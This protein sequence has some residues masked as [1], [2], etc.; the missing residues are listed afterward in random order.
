MEEKLV[1]AISVNPELY[2]MCD[3]NNHNREESQWWEQIG[4][5][6]NMIGELFFCCF[7]FLAV[8]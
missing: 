7:C 8:L 1:L 6:L 2:D 5:T 4:N 3:K